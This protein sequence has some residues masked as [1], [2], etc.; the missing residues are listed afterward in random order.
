MKKAAILT[1]IGLAVLLGT[2]FFLTR[3]KP[4]YRRT[5]VDF[6]VPDVTLLNQ[7]G[8]QVV[9]REFLS[10]EL[11][12]LLEFTF[13]S[14]TSFCPVQAAVYTNFQKK[15]PD[16]RQARLVSIT[17]DPDID[18]PAV[19]QD[20]LA[21]YHARPGWD[22]LT[23]SR[24]DI[25][26]VMEAFHYRPTNMFSLEAALLMRSARTG[27]WFQIDGRLDGESLVREYRRLEAE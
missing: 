19:L 16:S 9:L 25:Q 17:V 14:C 23:G 26:Q 15:L 27:K 10:P 12:L 6:L 22:F 18:T 24:A 1:V 4:P 20:H 2:L 13:T 21:R 7:R 3:E 11:P 5:Q 8:E